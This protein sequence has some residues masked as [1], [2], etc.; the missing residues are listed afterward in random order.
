[1]LIT[2]KSGSGKTTFCKKLIQQINRKFVID[3]L[4]REYEG[5]PNNDYLTWLDTYQHQID[6]KNFYITSKWSNPV[7]IFGFFWKVIDA[8]ARDFMHAVL[9]IE[10]IS[11]YMGSNFIDDNLKNLILLGRHG[12]LNLIGVTQRLANVHNDFISNAESIITFAQDGHREMAILRE[13]VEKE[14]LS[15][16]KNLARGEYVFVK[17][18]EN[19]F[20]FYK[21]IQGEKYHAEKFK[22]DD[23]SVDES[24]GVADL[25]RHAQRG[26]VGDPASQAD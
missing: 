17:G 9:I 16:I 4:R 26:L 11:L 13:Y 7:E 23:Q 25:H 5:F 12:R 10:E 8:D 20:D 14:N 2:G 1:M 22:S 6:L 19:F 3:S 21:P 18:R 24:D 15:T